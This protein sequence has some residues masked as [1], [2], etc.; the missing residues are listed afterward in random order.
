MI[1]IRE[2]TV[3]QSFKDLSTFEQCGKCNQAI[4]IIIIM[5]II[6]LSILLLSI[7]FMDSS[8]VGSITFIL[9][10]EK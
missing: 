5:I 10:S 9:I 8:T 2:E 1:L 3:L 6:I 7:I 4:V